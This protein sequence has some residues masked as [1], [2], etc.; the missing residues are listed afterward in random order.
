MHVFDCEFGVVFRSSVREIVRVLRASG[1]C[2]TPI[3]A[4]RFAR[5]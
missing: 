1:L 3:A 2:A 5:A 4:L